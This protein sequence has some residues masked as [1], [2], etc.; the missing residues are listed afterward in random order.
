MATKFCWVL[1]EQFHVE[2]PNRLFIHDHGQMAGVIHLVRT[3]VYFLGKQQWSILVKFWKF[4]NNFNPIYLNK[5]I[6]P[7]MTRMA[8]ITNV[9]WNH[10]FHI[11]RSQRAVWEVISETEER[12]S[13]YY[14]FEIMYHYS[15]LKTTA[16]SCTLIQP[17]TSYGRWTN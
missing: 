2:F 10:K 13:Y 4:I 9:E 11:H 12:G 3:T 14:Y 1:W 15:K 7:C 17:F 8:L 5:R 6:S 16:S